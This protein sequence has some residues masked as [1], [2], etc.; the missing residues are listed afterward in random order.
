[1]ISISNPVPSGLAAQLSSRQDAG[2]LLDQLTHHT[3][4]LTPTG[5]HRDTYRIQELLRTYL[6]ADLQRQGPTR[7]ADLHTTAAHWWADQN[8]PASALD[9]ATRSHN[10]ALLSELLHRFALPLIL[11][12]HHPALRR[13]LTTLG[14]HATASDPWL[15]LTYAITQLEAGDPSAAR[16]HLRHAQTH[17]P[18]H[19][20]ADLTV[21]QTAAQQ[22]ATP[23][24]DT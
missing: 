20:T 22:L 3:A 19:D 2:S 16:T 15:A 8:H 17:W 13:A 12:G 14:A 21:L 7:V 11:T 23:T 5:Q 9:H 6:I 1:M 4:L 24:H 10:P 18:N